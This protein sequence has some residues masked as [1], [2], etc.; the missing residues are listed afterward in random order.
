MAY[1]SKI[2]NSLGHLEYAKCAQLVVY[3]IFKPLPPPPCQTAGKKCN[4]MQ[5]EDADEESIAQL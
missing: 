2:E 5:M 1:T 4:L 3:R